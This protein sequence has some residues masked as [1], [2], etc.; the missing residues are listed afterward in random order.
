MPGT[1]FG[2]SA[3]Q[4]S[5]MFAIGGR[6]I[7]RDLRGMPETLA[8]A[9]G[10]ELKFAVTKAEIRAVQKMRYRVFFEEGGAKADPLTRARMRDDCPFDRLCDHII[11]VDHDAAARDGRCR[12]HVA[13]AYR[14]LRQ[15]AV[16]G[17]EH[18]YAAGEFDVASLVARHPGKRFLELGR[19]CV[20]A[21]YRSRRV[22]ELLWRG[23]WA[24]VR[25]HRIDVMFGCASLPGTDI[26]AH[27]ASLA[28]L[29]AHAGAH[30]DWRVG[31][32]SGQAHTRA[33]TTIAD[34]APGAPSAG[35]ILAALPPLVKGYLRV[36]ASFS[37][38]VFIDRAFGTTDVF[39]TLPVTDIE[40]RYIEHFGGGVLE[41]AA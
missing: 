29:A 9:G 15:D 33:A 4:G 10:L 21:E 18:F 41:Q 7:V 25:H 1:M 2:G 5:A 31:S 12:T 26:A 6:R 20:L 38:S 19:S 16:R 27:A 39:V 35:R 34:I 8:R 14:V 40:A 30:E 23:V 36:G 32:A 24:Y 17:P 13:G 28:F 11:V 37:E 3:E 22:L